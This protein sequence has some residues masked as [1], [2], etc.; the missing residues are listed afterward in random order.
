MFKIYSVLTSMV[1]FLLTPVAG[2]ILFMP[3][4]GHTQHHSQ[5]YWLLQGTVF[6]WGF[7]WGVKGRGEEGGW[8]KPWKV[9]FSMPMGPEWLLQYQSFMDWQTSCTP[10]LN[11]DFADV[12]CKN[13]KPDF[14]ETLIWKIQRKWERICIYFF[15]F[16]CVH[17]SQL[18]T[19]RP[20]NL[21]SLD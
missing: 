9:F 1:A 16:R 3:A 21:C 18:Y 4:L 5:S 14:K 6:G 20:F 19:C 8:K 15:T 10:A 17:S 12:G 7:F 11:L 2:I 13:R